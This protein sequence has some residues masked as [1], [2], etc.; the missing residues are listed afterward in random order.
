MSSSTHKRHFNC[1]SRSFKIGTP[2]QSPTSL[3]F[4]HIRQITYIFD[5]FS[6]NFDQMIR[7]N[8]LHSLVPLFTLG[9]FWLSSSITH[10]K[11]QFLLRIP[12]GAL[13]GDPTAG[14]GCLPVG[15][16]GCK[17][18]APRN[19]F[20]LDFDDVGYMWTKE[21]CMMDSDGD[22]MTNGHELGDPCCQ[23]SPGNDDVLRTSGLSH[24][25]ITDNVTAVP[26]P[27]CNDQE[28]P[29]SDPVATPY[30]TR[31]SPPNIPTD[32]WE[33]F[34]ATATATLEDR[35]KKPLHLLRIGDVVQVGPSKFSPVFMFTHRLSQGMYTF[36]VISGTHTT[37]SLTPG[38]YL[39]I[40]DRLTMAK[41][42]RPGDRLRLADG[43][44]DIVKSVNMELKQGLYNPQTLHGDIV[45]DGVL[46]STY[47]SAIAP[48]V[49]HPLLAPLR[50]IFRHTNWFTSVS[51]SNADCLSRNTV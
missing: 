21:L 50:M 5:P 1:V 16:I 41:T 20:G 6:R 23:W 3:Y 27:N 13:A 4:S 10:A 42:V 35:S 30:P 33:C 39:Y 19:A 47:T 37:I 48:T 38:H 40:N 32:I 7:L 29:D 51:K 17:P 31:S 25:G 14:I 15:H 22:G 28:G 12:N 26:M 18:G 44:E 2:R 46:A 45:V 34:P 24:P 11:P 8:L 49:A 9:T 43:S 36:V